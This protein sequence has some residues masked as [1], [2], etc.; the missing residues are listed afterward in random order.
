MF[1][2][3]SDETT[4][5]SRAMLRNV[6]AQWLCWTGLPGSDNGKSAR[7]WTAKSRFES[8]PR[9]SR[10]LRTDRVQVGIWVAEFIS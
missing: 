2:S 4:R 3:V 10:V 5:G 6:L 9:S 8:W 1:A 7:L